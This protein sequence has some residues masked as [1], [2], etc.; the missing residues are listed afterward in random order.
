MERESNFIVPYPP[1]PVISLFSL[2]PAPHCVLECF[3]PVQSCKYQFFLN[4]RVFLSV[5]WN[6]GHVFLYSLHV[7]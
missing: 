1:T 7:L 5:L 4:K 6:F 3:K 2:F